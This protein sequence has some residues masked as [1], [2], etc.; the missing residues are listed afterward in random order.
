MIN[1]QKIWNSHADRSQIG[2]IVVRTD[3]SV[4]KH[5][6]LSVFLLEMKTPGITVRP[7]IDMTGEEN[8]YN[9]VFLDDVR[10]PAAHRLGPEGRRL[11]HRHG[12]TADRASGHDQTGGGLGLRSNRA[13]IA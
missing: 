8:E 10:V 7:I 11:A 9:E 6:G 1:G 3:S 2:V 12:A 4:P 5:K 13:R